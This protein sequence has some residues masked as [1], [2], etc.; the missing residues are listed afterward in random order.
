MNILFLIDD[1][2]LGGAQRQLVSLSTKFHSLGHK[3]S[4]LTYSR[5]SLHENALLENGIKVINVEDQ[6]RIKILFKVRKLIRSGRFNVVISFL[7]PPNFINI[8]SGFPKRDWKVIVSERSS[9]PAILVSLKSRIIRLL[10]LFA[11]IVIANSHANMRLLLKINPFILG[12]KCKVI[13]NAIDLDKY[14]PSPQFRFRT[15]GFLKIVVLASYRK[16]K[17]ILNLIEAVNLLTI[18]EQ[19]RLVIEWYGDKTPGLHRDGILD[20]AVNLVKKYDLHSV[21]YLFSPS[22]NIISTIQSADVI[23]LF[24]YFEGLPNAICEGMACGKPIIATSVSDIPL[25]VKD[26]EN[27]ILC[28]AE[29]IYSIVNAL[30]YLLNASVATLAMLGKTS[31]ERAEH[32]FDENVIAGQYLRLIHS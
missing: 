9:N 17:N 22:Y 31:R 6:Q 7:G 11:D 12:S 19:K 16:L 18:N 26:K 27:G 3:I 1:L 10:Y 5:N 30:R 14:K 13:Y 21:I 2:G 29:D 25:I 4:V 15:F 20:E 32:L 8:V 28:Q 23:G 24:S